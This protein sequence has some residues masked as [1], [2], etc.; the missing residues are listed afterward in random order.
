MVWH[1][2]GN[3]LN[4]DTM[5][6]G[7]QAKASTTMCSWAATA[8][9]DHYN[10]QG[11][12][13]FG[14]AMDLSRAFDLV[15]WLELFRVLRRRGV[16]P[17]FLRGLLNIYAN[18]M[19]DVQW[20]GMS[21]F[22]F[23]VTNGVRQGSVSSPILFSVYIDDLFKILRASGFGCRVVNSF[24]GC[25]GYADD[26]LVLSA[27]RSGLQS[28]INLCSD[29]ALSKSLKF[30]TNKDPIKSK[31]K[32]IIFTKK[33]KK[34]ED[35]PPVILNGDPLPWVSELKHLGNIL[36]V[37]NSMKK[38]CSTKRANFVG[39]L[40]SLQQEFHFV[41]PDILVKIL[42]IYAVSFYGSALWDIFSADCDRFYKAW[43]VCIRIIFN[44]DRRTHRYLI[45]PLSNSLHPQVMLA[46]RFVKFLR[47]LRTSDKFGTLS[48]PWISAQS[49]EEVSHRSL[50]NATV[51]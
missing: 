38:D 35:I 20:N 26:L 18:Q 44:L 46:S 27:S 39:K 10:R 23:S 12:D 22:K 34:F 7:F 13:V 24:F 50:R 31:T 1:L 30:S 17:V 19:C 9:I 15:E 2:E 48:V 40:N 36:E 45:E 3:K 8:V 11:R 21:S 49:L 28:M 4:C 33:R 5:Q 25:F 32:C 43:N 29:F 51:L 41:K 14:C 16:A 47:T 42:N 6:F 37:D